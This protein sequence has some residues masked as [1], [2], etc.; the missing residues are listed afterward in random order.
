MTSIVRVL[1]HMT[2]YISNDV[3]K[4]EN[5]SSKKCATSD[6]DVITLN[7]QPGQHI[8]IIVHDFRF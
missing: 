4:L 8:S 5:G 6:S 1:S 2:Y 3:T 7:A